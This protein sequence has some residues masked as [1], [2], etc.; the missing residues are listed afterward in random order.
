MSFCVYGIVGEEYFL[1][2]S[3]RVSW[4]IVCYAKPEEDGTLTV[5][6]SVRDIS[7]DYDAV[8]RLADLCNKH[9]LSP[10]HLRDVIDDFFK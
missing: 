4:G 9:S 2:D 6:A 1:N 5:I 3:R 10:L 8:R 7:P